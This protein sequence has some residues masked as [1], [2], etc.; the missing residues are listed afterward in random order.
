MGR[1]P[2]P[3]LLMTGSSISSV[4][5]EMESS[6]SS[7]SCAS[8][9]CRS[10]DATNRA[11]SGGAISRAHRS[12]R[13]RASPGSS[14]RTGGR[15]LRTL[16]RRAACGGAGAGGRWGGMSLSH[17][18]HSS[19]APSRRSSTSP[20]CISRRAAGCCSSAG[21]FVADHRH[22]GRADRVLTRGDPLRA[23]A[24]IMTRTRPASASARPLPRRTGR[25]GRRPADRAL[26]T[27]DRIVKRS[28][29]ADT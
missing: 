22:A 2:P 17:T 23:S 12:A 19:A 8:R 4:P 16:A 20:R 24:R 9:V 13:P 1:S 15:G 14:V 21:R 5:S 26:R 25:A 27:A 28:A 18:A 6:R 3:Q 10:P 29:A 7:A 11:S